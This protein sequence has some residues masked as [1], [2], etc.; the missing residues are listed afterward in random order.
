MTTHT[1]E[2]DGVTQRY[3]VHGQGPLCLMHSGGPGIAWD[4][5]RMPEVEKHV[6]AVYIEPVGTPDAD[7]LAGHPHGYTRER[8]AKAIDGVIDDLGAPQVYL[9]G[10]SHGGFVAQH[11]AL[12]RPSRLAGVILYE[13]SPVTGPELFMEAQRNFEKFA[14]RFA[15]HPELP[16]ITK[17]WRAVPTIDDDETMTQVLR[18]LLPVYLKDYWAGES[19]FSRLRSNV[20]GRHVSGLDDNLQPEVIDDRAAL[21]TL[22]VPALVM[23]GTYDFICGPRW[24][25]E[26][27][28]RIPGS[29]L[30]VL[31]DSG[32]F[33]HIE[34]PGEF[35]RA[36]ADF[37]S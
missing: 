35:A 19:D 24:A 10:H 34:Q 26:L 2:I 11:F 4:Y 9:L 23:V 27:H 5:L 3:H 8:Y 20:R 22:S 13:S 32:H 31:A 14:V 12:T 37:T 7:R 25:Q 17:A 16:E 36:I 29:R 6:T 21:G 1:I 30:A 18:T 15:G 28:D 33:G